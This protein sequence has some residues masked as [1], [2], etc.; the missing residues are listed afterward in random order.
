MASMLI[1]EEL[2]AMG[3]C[4]YHLLPYQFVTS[5]TKA[6]VATAK[7]L[8][9]DAIPLKPEEPGAVTDSILQVYDKDDEPDCVKQMRGLVA[10]DYD[11]VEVDEP[12]GVEALLEKE[13]EEDTGPRPFA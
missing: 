3:L 9:I 11:I 8:I 5:N 1:D 13:E 6:W 12:M 7:H 2:E 4:R 10:N